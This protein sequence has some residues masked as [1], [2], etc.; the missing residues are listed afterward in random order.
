MQLL[1]GV[2]VLDLTNVLAGPFCCYQLGRRLGS[3]GLGNGAAAV[4]VLSSI[5][6]AVALLLYAL[7]RVSFG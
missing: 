3:R 1:E 7:S 4:A 2:R 6:T 5:A